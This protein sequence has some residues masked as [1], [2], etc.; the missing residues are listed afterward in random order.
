MTILYDNLFNFILLVFILFICF[1]QIFYPKIKVTPKQIE[2]INFLYKIIIPSTADISFIFNNP[3]KGGLYDIVISTIVSERKV[4]GPLF[5][6]A[7]PNKPS[8]VNY[9]SFKKLIRGIKENNFPLKVNISE[10]ENILSK[11]ITKRFIV[12]KDGIKDYQ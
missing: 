9:N 1:L 10:L 7:G 11:P 6:L 8:F 12:S 3:L 4:K 2:V 5:F